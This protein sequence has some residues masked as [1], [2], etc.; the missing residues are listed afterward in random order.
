[1]C[2]IAPNAALL[3][4][5][6]HW[7]GVVYTLYYL[8]T[9]DLT[10]ALAGKIF[11]LII[12]IPVSLAQII[13]ITISWT[14]LR[15]IGNTHLRD[16][17]WCTLVHKVYARWS[18]PLPKLTTVFL[19]KKRR[20]EEEDRVLKSNWLESQRKNAIYQ[21]YGAIPFE[22]NSKNEEKQSP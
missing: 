14:Q 12:E 18:S 10:P 5:W 1:M 13:M 16:R 9:H 19:E 8:K 15:E 20:N 6:F 4:V 22:Q 7:T 11:S 17:E 21:T 3:K 2:V